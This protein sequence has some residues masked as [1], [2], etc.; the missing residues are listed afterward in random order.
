MLEETIKISISGSYYFFNPII[1][2]GSGV[3]YTQA[4]EQV[5]E[6]SYTMVSKVREKPKY[7]LEFV[8]LVNSTINNDRVE[9]GYFEI[10][11]ENNTIIIKPLFDSEY[12]LEGADEE[13]MEYLK[14][15]NLYL[16]V[17]KN[18]MSK[19]LDHLKFHKIILNVTSKELLSETLMDDLLNFINREELR[20]VFNVEINGDYKLI[21]PMLKTI[22]LHSQLSLR[23]VGNSFINFKD[24][25]GLKIEYI[26]IDDS[27]INLMRKNRNWGILLK[28]V[29][30]ILSGQRTKILA[31]HYKDERVLKISN[32]LKQFG[33]EEGENSDE[34]D[35]KF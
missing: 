23:K 17:M 21:L 26:E 24:I 10:E 5:L 11:G 15:F 12:G 9:M 18:L 29:K 3:N 14:E 2:I 35:F 30:L 20:V 1:V 19:N 33:K 16:Q 4:K 13:I 31:N 32:Q 22:K 25:Y 27:L 8:K 28:G 7:E 6:S 34:L